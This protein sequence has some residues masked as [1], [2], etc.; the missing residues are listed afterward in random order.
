M[1]DKLAK[2]DE[3][4]NNEDTVASSEA[5]EK[6]DYLEIGRRGFKRLFK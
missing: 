5:F 6:R 4:Q 2:F 1:I 3:K